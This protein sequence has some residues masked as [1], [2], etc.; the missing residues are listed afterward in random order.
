[1]ANRAPGKRLIL[2]RGALHK[3]ERQQGIRSQQQCM[4]V[5]I[6]S[7]PGE[8]VTNLVRRDSTLYLGAQTEWTRDEKSGFSTNCVTHHCFVSF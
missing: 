2:G 3:Q 4:S 8:I 1:M 7:H 6:E 5:F